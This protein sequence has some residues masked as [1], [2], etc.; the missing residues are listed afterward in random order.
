MN[1]GISETEINN[2]YGDLHLKLDYDDLGKDFYETLTSG[3]GKKLF[4][5]L[6]PANNSYHV[7][8]EL[9]CKNGDEEFRP[10]ITI[11]INGMPLVFIEVKK[12][13]NKEGVLAERI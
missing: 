1:P 7:T 13:N 11:L 9:T 10:D 2:L 3:T 12:P 4:D 6:N 5:F 8:T